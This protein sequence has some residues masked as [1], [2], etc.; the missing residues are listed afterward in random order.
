M[1]GNFGIKNVFHLHT[2]LF[3]VHAIVVRTKDIARI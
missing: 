1:N 2:R 3:L